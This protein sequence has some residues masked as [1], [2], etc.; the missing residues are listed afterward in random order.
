[1]KINILYNYIKKN[2]KDILIHILHLLLA[3]IIILFVFYIRLLPRVSRE[4]W[5][6]MNNYQVLSSVIKI[7]LV[8]MHIYLLL[9][10]MGIIEQK[11][12]FPVIVSIKLFLTKISDY[13]TWT[14]IN[15]YKFF[16]YI[17]ETIGMHIYQFPLVKYTFIRKIAKFLLDS[18][19]FNII[20]I[21]LLILS[22]GP[23]LIFISAFSY[24]V[25][26]QKQ[27]NYTFLCLPLLLLTLFEKLILFMFQDFYDN[28]WNNISSYVKVTK[29]ET[30]TGPLLKYEL[31]IKDERNLPK[32]LGN[33]ENLLNNHYLVIE[34]VGVLLNY[35]QFLKERKLPYYAICLGL[36]IIRLLLLIFILLYG[37]I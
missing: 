14:L 29:L 30:P 21:F 11:N 4:L 20:F 31:T 25:L 34:A 35:Y 26:V 16:W 37:T 36:C 33:F 7:G 5:E 13:F 9:R 12:R 3:I 10:L 19:S 24:D 6:Q 32:I 27:L 17:I 1:M 2:Y 22:L 15:L 28:N 18:Q 8:I 23:K